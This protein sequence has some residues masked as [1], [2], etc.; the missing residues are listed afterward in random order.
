MMQIYEDTGA[1]PAFKKA[2]ITIGTFDGVHLGHRQI[3]RQLLEEAIAIGGTPVLISFYPHPKQV[4]NSHQQ[5]IFMLNTPA[6]KAS[7]LEKAG[8]LHLVIVPFN[9]S[10]AGQ[11]AQQYIS[12]FLVKS[13][14]PHTIIIGYDHRFGHNREGDYKLL[15]ASAQKYGYIVKEIPEHILKDITISSTVI[16]RALT[17]GD[18][19]TANAFLGYRYFFSGTVIEGNKLGRTIGY[20][21]ANLSVADPEKLVPGNG[22][23][24]VQVAIERDERKLNGMM[25]IG[26]RPT[27]GGSQRVIEVNIF[28]FNEMIYGRRLQITLVDRLRTEVKFNGLDELKAQLGADK[29]QATTI[30]H[31]LP[32]IQ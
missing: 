4:V 25:N 29:I 20:P 11:T 6:E 19:A 10:F 28:E 14:Q 27:V 12:D 17:S 8:I 30:L 32:L 26:I 2:V 7:L 22:V 15:E 16:R 23:Y 1:L 31:Q 13:F 21:T 24:A 9:T 18:I 5:P 3:I